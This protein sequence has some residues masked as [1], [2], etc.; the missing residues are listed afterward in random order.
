MCFIIENSGI[1]RKQSEED[2]VE[3]EFQG[4]QPLDEQQ[5]NI[6]QGLKEQFLLISTKFGGL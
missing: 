4:G 6:L 3:E 2:N 5:V 1:E